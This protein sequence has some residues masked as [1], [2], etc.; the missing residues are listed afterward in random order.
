MRG[1]KYALVYLLLIQFFLGSFIPLDMVYANR[2]DYDLLKDNLNHIDTILSKLQKE[3][4]KNEREYIIILGDSVAFSGPGDSENSLGVHL[5]RK[6]EE[7]GYF[8]TINELGKY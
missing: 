1:L 3:I 4:A 5:A 6:F 7:N 8:C 2:F